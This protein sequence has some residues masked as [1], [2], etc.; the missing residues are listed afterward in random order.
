MASL[1]QGRASYDS[2][3]EQGLSNSGAAR[4]FIVEDGRTQAVRIQSVLE[5]AGHQVEVCPDGAT[6]LARFNQ[7]PPDLV[8][9]DVHLPD[10]NGKEVARRMR[11]APFGE[12]ISILFMTAIFREIADI[13]S[14]LNE[15]ADDY[16]VK[17]VEDGEL[18][19]R[20]SATLRAKANHRELARTARQLLAV[21]QV[22][23]RIAAILDAEPLIQFVVDNLQKEF[24]FPHVHVLLATGPE[25]I[26]AGGTV[27]EKV[28]TR[29]R[30]DDR[31][32]LSPVS[33]MMDSP[34]FDYFPEALM[35]DPLVE[36]AAHALAVP[37]R[38]ADGARGCLEINSPMPL[39]LSKSDLLTLQTLADVLAVALHNS[40][41]YKSQKEFAS[42]DELTGISNRRTILEVL[43]TEFGRA[44]RYKRPL[45]VVCVDLDHFKTINDTYGHAVGDDALQA[46]CAQ[47][48][49]TIRAHD[50]LGR[51]GG[52]EFLMVLPETSAAD[53]EII[54]N[55]LVLQCRQAAIHSKDGRSVKLT[56]SLGIASWPEQDA[57]DARELI[58]RGDEALYRAKNA[59]RNRVSR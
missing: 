32:G 17:P 3:V 10:M 38:A 14:G 12:S 44:R 40:R 33:L 8:L 2:F 46:L 56:V 30:M 53:A 54:S 57:N 27:K 45:S 18:L 9:L 28:S 43:E 21:N 24:G 23:R 37:F 58:K 34:V 48:R 51:I 31:E 36:G 19:A 49:G 55:R 22:S 59:G 25:L 26:V 42:R 47:L 11:D 50:S 35:R 4:I 41:L 29:I 52:D 6:A 39:Q 7:A 15:G 1:R 20:V 5:E 13:V 16:L